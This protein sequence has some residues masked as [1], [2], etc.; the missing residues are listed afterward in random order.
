L[1]TLHH[2]LLPSLMDETSRQRNRAF[3]GMVQERVSRE[4]AFSPTKSRNAGILPEPNSPNLP[5]R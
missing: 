4:T 5:R 2:A 1:L 3:V